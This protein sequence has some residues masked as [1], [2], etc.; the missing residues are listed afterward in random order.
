M[1]LLNES[2]EQEISRT[3]SITKQENLKTTLIT[4]NVVK[5]HHDLGGLRAIF[6]FSYSIGN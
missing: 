1:N 2:W 6:G 3:D 4:I 5:A